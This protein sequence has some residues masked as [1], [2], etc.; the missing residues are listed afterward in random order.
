MTI[1]PELWVDHASRA[2]E[3]YANAFGASV[4]HL[5]GKGD[6]I[7]AQLAVGEAMFWVAAAGPDMGRFS[8]HEVGGATGRIL[9]MADDP[10]AV[11]RQAIDAGAT[12]VSA[13][14]EEHGWRRRRGLPSDQAR[15]A[16]AA[17]RGS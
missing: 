13:V 1:Q 2:V 8:P 15:P 11:Q 9:L 7:V 16:A 4:L 10:E 5:V 14:G 12:E 3:F 17:R 6:D